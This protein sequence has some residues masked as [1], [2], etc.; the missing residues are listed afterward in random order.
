MAARY[1]ESR[2]NHTYYV[3]TEIRN[4]LTGVGKYAIIR[5]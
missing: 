3:Y 2:E 5:K 1:D 4:C